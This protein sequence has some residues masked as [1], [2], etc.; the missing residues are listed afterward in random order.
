MTTEHYGG[1]RLSTISFNFPITWLIPLGHFPYSSKLA[2]IP[3]ANIA[4]YL[5]TRG[6][7]DKEGE[8]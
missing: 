8:P 4:Q 3:S 1:R 2:E 6:N 7:M 5:Y